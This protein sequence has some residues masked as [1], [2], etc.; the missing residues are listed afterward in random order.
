MSV[1]DEQCSA[2]LLAAGLR[3]D[4][5]DNSI[6]MRQRW[7]LSEIRAEEVAF[8]LLSRFLN[9]LEAQVSVAAAAC[10]PHIC[11][12][13]SFSEGHGSAHVMQE[14]QMVMQHLHV[15]LRTKC[16]LPHHGLKSNSCR[17]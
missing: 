5:P 16:S 14:L 11:A 15:A 12:G 17:A 8:V 2:R 10:N 1:C 13:F 9:V 4:A 6:S 3:N 7:R